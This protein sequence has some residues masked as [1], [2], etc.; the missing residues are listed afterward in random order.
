MFIEI[1]TETGRYKIKNDPARIAKFHAD[2]AKKARR[3]APSRRSAEYP[4]PL[5]SETMAAYCIRFDK[6]NNFHHVATTATGPAVHEVWPEP[7]T[8]C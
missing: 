6:T 3:S 8:L 2:Y 7:E 4:I 5:P 1:K